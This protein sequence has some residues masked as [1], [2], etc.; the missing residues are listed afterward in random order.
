MSP[1]RQDEYAWTPRDS[2][3]LERRGAQRIAV[4][5]Q[6]AAQ[7][8]GCA[9]VRVVGTPE[10]LTVRFVCGGQRGELVAPFGRPIFWI[11]VD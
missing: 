5:Y 6:A 10:R 2:S 4:L 9:G 11:A 1:Q 8:S 3:E 7:N